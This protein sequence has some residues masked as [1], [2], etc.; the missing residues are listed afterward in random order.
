MKLFSRLPIFISFLFALHMVACGQNQPVDP[1]VADEFE[2]IYKEYDEA[3][4][5]RDISVVEKYLDKNYEL[6]DGKTTSKRAEVIKKVKDNFAAIE[7]VI[8]SSAKIEKIE[9]KDGSYFLRVSSTMVATYKLPNDK[10]TKVETVAVSTDVWTKT[11][12]GWKETKQIVHALKI[13]VDGKEA[14]R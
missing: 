12:D 9:I 2:K 10:I 3:A 6:Q 11:D 14:P 5:K 1:K 7:E 8:E 4:K 13:L